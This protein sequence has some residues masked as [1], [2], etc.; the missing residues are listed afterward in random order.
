M[1]RAG[2]ETSLAPALVC[3]ASHKE[4]HAVLRGLVAPEGAAH[5]PDWTLIRAPVTPMGLDVLITGVG[6]SNAAAAVA[7]NIEPLRHRFV[8]SLG[9]GGLL[10][11]H[12]L[13]LASSVLASASVFADEGAQTPDTFLD[14]SAMG[15]PPAPGLT[16]SSFPGHPLA[17]RALRELVDAVGHVA[18]VSTCSG[19]GPLA[20]EIAHRSGAMVEAMEG[21]AIALVAHRMNIPF[22]EVRIVS[23]TTGDRAEQRWD[24]DGALRA[25][26]RISSRLP[27]TLQL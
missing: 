23:N 4:A 13:D 17:H 25:L 15:F 2:R 24:I 12:A 11:G 14:I 26:E 7:R 21:A 27:A 1:S 9:I 22:A 20:R 16:G 8:L 10:P 3:V 18:T 19:T 6:K 5:A